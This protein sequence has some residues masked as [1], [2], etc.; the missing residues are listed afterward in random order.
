MSDFL[1]LAAASIGPGLLWLWYFYRLDRFEPEPPRIIFKLFLAGII[2]VIPAG[3]LE[4]FWRA[5]LI[6]AINNGTWQDL[7]IMAFFVIALIEEGLKTFLLW[8]MIGRQKELDEPADGII[9]GITLGLGFASL[10]NLLWA[11]IYGLGVAALRAVVTTLAH[12][13]FTGWA[14][15]YI[16]RYR[17]KTHNFSYVWGGFLI[18]LVSHGTYDFLL[19]TQNSTAS[20]L[21]FLLIAILL[22]QLYRILQAEVAQSPFRK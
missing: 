9:Y 1:G 19:F 11:S 2:L 22:F 13:S 14:G 10:E 18:A 21:A 12:A 4:H 3:L 5:R 15:Y 7:F 20:I 6:N 8:R 17:L 16:A